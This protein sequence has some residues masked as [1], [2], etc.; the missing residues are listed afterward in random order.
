MELEEVCFNVSWNGDVH[1][2]FYVVPLD[3]EAEISLPSP[4]LFDLVIFPEGFEQVI[5]V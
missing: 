5:D 4:V 1:I 2:S 3:C